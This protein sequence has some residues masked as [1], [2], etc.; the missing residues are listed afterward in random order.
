MINNERFINL[1]NAFCLLVRKPEI[2]WLDFLNTMIDDYNVFICVDVLDDYLELKNKY[3]YISFIEI[4]DETCL[5]FNYINSSYLFKSVI[6]SDRAF[7]YFNHI[8]NNYNHIWFC[9]DDVFFDNVNI[10][11]NLDNKYIN[12][13][14]LSN[15]VE[16]NNNGDL[17]T[18]DHW[19]TINN[20]F[21]LPWA[22]AMVCLVRVSNN[23]M[24]KLDEYIIKNKQ[25]IFLEIIFHTL[26]IHNEMIIET[27]EEL[28]KIYYRYNFKNEDIINDK[29]NNK[30]YIYH[31]IKNFKNHLILRSIK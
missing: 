18:W 17:I 6:S 12:A 10:I 7:Y 13:D 15:S 8:N 16:F 21:P 19:H 29:K 14:I 3:N 2:I 27:P 5:K 11:K 1:K 22:K 26:A 31:P 4:N 30:Y 23:L 9:E 28:S 20:T 25:M 24:K